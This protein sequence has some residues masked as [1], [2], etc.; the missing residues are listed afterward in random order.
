[1][2]NK[3]NGFE[4]IVFELFSDFKFIS[5]AVLFVLKCFMSPQRRNSDYY[6]CVAVGPG[7]KNCTPCLSTVS[8]AKTLNV[9]QKCTQQTTIECVITAAVSRR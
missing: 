7:G 3:N 6:K 5:S 2:R 9:M 8:V 1:M 4:K